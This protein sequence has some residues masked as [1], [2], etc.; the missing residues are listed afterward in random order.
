MSMDVSL[1]LS[2]LSHA[3]GFASALPLRMAWNPGGVVWCDGVTAAATETAGAEEVCV[4][5]LARFWWD[6]QMCRH[7]DRGFQ[8]VQ[9]E[10]SSLC[11]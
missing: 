11:Q 5:A 2:N 1:G 3:Q 7:A 10:L 6:R 9:Q 8:H 4:L